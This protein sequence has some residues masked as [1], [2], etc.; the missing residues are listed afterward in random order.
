[1]EAWRW[2]WTIFCGVGVVSFAVLV[3][4]VVPSGWLDI[5]RLFATLESRAE[6]AA[7]KPDDGTRSRA[8]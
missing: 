5:R 7:G 2:F 4:L 8:C 3:V 6:G 1:M